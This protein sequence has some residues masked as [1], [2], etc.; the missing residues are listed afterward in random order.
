MRKGCW[1]KGAVALIPATWRLS[2]LKFDF[3]GYS[4]GPGNAFEHGLVKAVGVSN[5]NVNYRPSN[6]NRVK[7]AC[8]ELEITLIAYS[9]IGQGPMHILFF[10]T[11]FGNNKCRYCEYTP[12]NPPSGPRG[13]IY[14]PEFLTKVVEGSLSDKEVEELRSLA[15]ETSP[16]IGFPVENL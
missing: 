15:S 5:Y 13:W 11:M 3:V 7:V 4:D 16:V 2:S 8:N 14:T 6:Q 9:P 12:K 1:D 10:N